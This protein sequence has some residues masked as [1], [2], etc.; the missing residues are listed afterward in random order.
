M[1][2][3][4]HHPPP[5]QVPELYW[6]CQNSTCPTLGTLLGLR[7]H[8]QSSWQTEQGVEVGASTVPPDRDPGGPWP[9][10]SWMSS[11]VLHS[12]PSGEPQEFLSR[13]SAMSGVGTNLCLLCAGQGS[14]FQASSP[15][16]PRPALLQSLF[17]LPSL[18]G[19]EGQSIGQGLGPGCELSHLPHC[20]A[21]SS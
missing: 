20:V 21:R 6:S 17:P 9:W 12:G 1:G 11:R 16:F 19:H 10:V 8:M 18:R 15:L 5:S 3:S 7:G 14:L 2:Q 4:H 13:G